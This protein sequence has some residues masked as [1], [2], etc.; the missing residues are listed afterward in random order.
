M[1]RPSASLRGLMHP[2]RIRNSNDYTFGRL[3]SG[4]GLSPRLGSCSVQQHV[5]FCFQLFGGGGDAVLVGDFEF[6]AS[7]RDWPIGG[8][9][10]CAKAGFGSLRQ[11]PYAKMLAA[12]DVLTEEIVIAVMPFE[13]QSQRTHEEFSALCRLRR[14]DRNAGDKQDVHGLSTGKAM[15]LVH[16]FRSSH[17]IAA[18]SF[19]NFGIKG[20]LATY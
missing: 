14:D 2:W 12:T 8:P 1:R 5:A 20:A 19:A 7:V 3:H 6:E 15:L 9:G 4:D 11:R 16:R 10:G 13:R 17:P 18:H